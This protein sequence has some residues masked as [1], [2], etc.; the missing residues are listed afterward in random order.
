MQIEHFSIYNGNLQF[1]LLVT[2]EEK[3]IGIGIGMALVGNYTFP[4]KH[5]VDETIY[6]TSGGM[7]INGTLYVPG[8]DPC[9]VKAGEDLTIEVTLGPATYRTTR[10]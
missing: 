5:V 10:E 7:R 3:Y 1:L 6:V 8:G 4:S 9:L 2:D